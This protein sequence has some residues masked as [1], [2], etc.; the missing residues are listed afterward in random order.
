MNHFPTHQER[1]ASREK[2]KADADNL[3]EFL[4][5]TEYLD[6]FF[7]AK[8]IAGSIA[9]ACENG[10]LQH[11]DVNDIQQAARGIQRLLDSFYD[12]FETIPAPKYV[13]TV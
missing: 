7:A 13:A 2:G 1:L 4:Q 8:G 5:Y 3:L 9:L 10:S 12:L 6:G 11:D